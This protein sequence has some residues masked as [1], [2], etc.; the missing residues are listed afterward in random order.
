MII[1]AVPNNAHAFWAS[2]PKVQ[3]V[4]SIGGLRRG[5]RILGLARY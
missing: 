2:S 3:I 4:P 5:H 1:L